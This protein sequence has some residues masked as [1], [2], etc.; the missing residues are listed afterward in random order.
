MTGRMALR[1][2]GAGSTE[3]SDEGPYHSREGAALTSTHT[4][5]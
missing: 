5:P 3:R 2:S 1:R 4:A